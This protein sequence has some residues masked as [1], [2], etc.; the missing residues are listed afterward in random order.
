MQFLLATIENEICYNLELLFL[1]SK[2]SK[3][4]LC[5]AASSNNVS[6]TTGAL[7][8]ITVKLPY[9]GFYLR[10]LNFCEI[11]EVLTSSQILIS[12]VATLLPPAR[13]YSYLNQQQS[14][15]Y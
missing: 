3:A 11:C 2:T 7:S 1:K 14:M 4:A 9:S 12:S 6:D 8:Q 15:I 13:S 10:G 5:V